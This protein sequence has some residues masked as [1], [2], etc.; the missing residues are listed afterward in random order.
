MHCIQEVPT[1]HRDPLTTLAC[2]DGRTDGWMDG[3]MDGGEL[4][5]QLH[6]DSDGDGCSR[7]HFFLLRIGT[8]A[9]HCTILERAQ[10][11]THSTGQDN[12]LAIG[13]VHMYI[14]TYIGG[15]VGPQLCFHPKS[16]SH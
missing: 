8:A 10:H 14:H 5:S 15:Y 12:T 4:L 7:R 9:L 2:V 1:L 13:L 3:W 11:T 6:N 16:Y